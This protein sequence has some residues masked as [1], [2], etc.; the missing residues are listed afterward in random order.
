ITYVDQRRIYLIGKLVQH[1]KALTD[2]YPVQLRM[3]HPVESQVEIRKRQQKGKG[4]GSK[5]MKEFEKLNMTRQ[6]VTNKASVFKR[7]KNRL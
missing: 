3:G 6:D 4:E 7:H 2:D 1:G 5:W